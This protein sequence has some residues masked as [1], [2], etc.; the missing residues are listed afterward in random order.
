LSERIRKFVADNKIDTSGIR[1]LDPFVGGGG[2]L[3]QVAPGGSYHCGAWA[4]TT[5]GVKFGL[6][7][8]PGVKGEVRI[9]HPLCKEQTIKLWAG[10]SD[11]A[12][13][14]YGAG[15]LW[16]YLDCDDPSA[17]LKLHVW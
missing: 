13:G 8:P 2:P 7:A 14:F 1:K 3:R 10:D 11:D 6:K 5:T 16:V 4:L 15:R 12:S 17:R 9:W